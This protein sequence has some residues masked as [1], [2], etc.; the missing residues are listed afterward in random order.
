V[1]YLLSLRHAFS[2]NFQPLCL[3]K[4]CYCFRYKK[5]GSI[6]EPLR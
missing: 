6:G 2:L 3:N 1:P 4:S 5:S